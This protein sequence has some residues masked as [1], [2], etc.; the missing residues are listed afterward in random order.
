M[1][2]VPIFRGEFIT[3]LL[4]EAPDNVRLD[5]EERL[6][7]VK[8]ESILVDEFAEPILITVAF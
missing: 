8:G 2:F 1:L 6:A 3:T 7:Q 5:P 4:P